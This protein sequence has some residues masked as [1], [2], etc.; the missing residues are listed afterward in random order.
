[1]KPELEQHLAQVAHRFHIELSEKYRRGQA[2]HGGRLFAKGLLFHIDAARDE[3][4]DLTSY[5]DCMREDAKKIHATVL[6]ALG[7]TVPDCALRAY[8][9]EIK[10]LLEGSDQ[11][12]S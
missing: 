8:L 4:I 5:T 12:G 3:N 10:V 6:E 9:G 2:E 11:S 7:P 1:V